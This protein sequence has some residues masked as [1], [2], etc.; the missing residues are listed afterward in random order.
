MYEIKYNIISPVMTTVR[1]SETSVYFET[2][3]RYIPESYLHTRRRENLKSQISQLGV[4]IGYPDRLCKPGSEFNTSGNKRK[5]RPHSL[6]EC[7][8]LVVKSIDNERYVW[9]W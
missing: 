8:T 1:I 9:W 3:R 4:N 7:Y 2:T 5:K 6:C